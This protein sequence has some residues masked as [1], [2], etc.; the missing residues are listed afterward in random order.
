MEYYIPD[1]IWTCCILAQSFSFDQT[2]ALFTL[3]NEVF[4][5]S[6]SFTKHQIAVSSVILVSSKWFVWWF[7]T[8]NLCRTHVL[9]RMPSSGR[10]GSA[11]ELLV[12]DR[13]EILSE[14]VL[15]RGCPL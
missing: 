3:V 6:V 15:S 13:P 9:C 14:E 11:V 2:K 8:W 5:G 12:S 10:K 7:A 1:I 4:L